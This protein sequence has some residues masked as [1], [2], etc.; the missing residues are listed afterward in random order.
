MKRLV[1]V[2]AG[3]A[4]IALMAHARKLRAAGFSLELV[5]PGSFWYGGAVGRLMAARLPRDALRLALRAFCRAHD[6]RY[7]C[8]R[9]VGLERRH[10]RVW[11][12]TGA[13]LHYHTVSLDVGQQMPSPDFDEAGTGVQVWRS[14]APYEL[15]QCVDALAQRNGS[16]CNPRILVAGAGTTA[17]EIVA[18][19]CAN[20]H[21]AS[22]GKAWLI[23][24]DV[25]LPRAPRRANRTLLRYLAA[26]NVDCVPETT[27]AGLAQRAV[28]SAA[29]PRFSAGHLVLAGG[30][31][32]ARF[33]HATGLASDE[34]GLQV[35]ARLQASADE[36]VYAVGG[37]ARLA[38]HG[39]MD[40]ADSH[41]QARVL[42]H[43]IIAGARNRPFQ[44]YRPG[45][46]PAIV[47]LCDG[48]AL[49]WRGGVHLRSAWLA[50]RRQARDAA[51]LALIRAY[52]V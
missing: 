51:W 21:V 37:C 24:G 26:H 36:R 2:G 22:C 10:R 3:H 45:R 8:D 46:R 31:Q 28:V 48:S 15:A 50:R 6:V 47:D 16:R 30:A 52:P 27:V 32:A 4:H 19:L 40:A 17:A 41:R 39:E 33:A 14:V 23:P 25:P 11:L 42:L 29:G 34:H 38:H 18:G 35:N 12:A 1:L 20:P 5:D 7:R 43:N 9:A 44:R 13:M 49:G